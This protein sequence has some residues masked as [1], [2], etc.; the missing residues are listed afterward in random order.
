MGCGLDEAVLLDNSFTVTLTITTVTLKCRLAD[1]AT[2][3]A[4]RLWSDNWSGLLWSALRSGFLS[5]ILIPILVLCY[6]RRSVGQSLCDTAFKKYESHFF[7]RLIGLLC[8]VVL[9]MVVLL[10]L[11]PASCWSLVWT[12]IRVDIFHRSVRWLSPYNTA[13]YARRLT[14]SPPLVWEPQIQPRNKYREFINGS[15]SWILSAF[16]S[17][18]WS[19]AVS[20]IGIVSRLLQN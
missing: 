7:R 6:G 13:F 1:D 19:S 16:L 8:F 17:F 18:V 15:A 9:E 3:L 4:H 20:N 14:S 10:C 11:L 12:N 2:L 5:L